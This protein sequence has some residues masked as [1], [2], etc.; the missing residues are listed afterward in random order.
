MRVA[1]SSVV[2]LAIEPRSSDIIESIDTRLEKRGLDML[3]VTLSSPSSTL[4]LHDCGK[5][6][7]V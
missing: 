6:A 5:N 2:V 1:L 3:S 4:E 7:T